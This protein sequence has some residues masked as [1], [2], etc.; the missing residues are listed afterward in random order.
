MNLKQI[1]KSKNLTR[2]QISDKLGVSINTVASW[3]QGI[4]TPPLKRI[5]DLI[6]ILD[7]KVSDLIEEE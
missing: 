4:R 3:E 1:R 5:N 2:K 6:K 7:V